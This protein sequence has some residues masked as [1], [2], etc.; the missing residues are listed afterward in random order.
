VEEVSA[1]ACGDG[2]EACMTCSASEC[3]VPFCHDGEC[4]EAAAPDDTVCEAGACTAGKCNPCR[5]RVCFNSECAV[6][7][8]PDGIACG[9][10]VVCCNGACSSSC[11]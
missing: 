3:R 7:N 6:G 5:Q 9:D 2:G 8:V 1:D 10:D 11:G 4:T